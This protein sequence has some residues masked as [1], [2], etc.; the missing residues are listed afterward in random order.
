MA[1]PLL[2]HELDE[3]K[4]TA[5]HYAACSSQK[6]TQM[7]VEAGSSLKLQDKFGLT[8]LHLALEMGHEHIAEYLLKLDQKLDID[9]MCQSGNTVLHL[10]SD[11]GFIDL[12]QDILKRNPN[13]HLKDQDGETVLH[14]AV[15]NQCFEMVQ[16]LVEQSE[17]P[18]DIKNLEGQTALEVAQECGSENIAN[19]LRAVDQAQQERAILEQDTVSKNQTA[20]KSPEHFSRRL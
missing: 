11:W 5:L 1:D 12:A 2:V 17:V 19:Y 7:L 18:L 14:A 9:L 10:A 13:V 4:R 3:N 16:L 15:H 8:P 6:M 20:S